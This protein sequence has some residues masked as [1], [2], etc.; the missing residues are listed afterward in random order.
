MDRKIILGILSVT[1][2]ALALSIL[3]PGGR[4]VDKEPKLPWLI[5][6]DEEGYPSVFGITLGKSTLAELRDGFQ[7]Q[8]EINL[9]VT[10]Q[11][12]HAIEAYFQS[13]YLSGI[14]AD[15]VVT[16]DLE[17]PEL[18]GMYDRGL[19][20]SQLES[21]AKKVTLS[22]PDLVTLERA[23]VDHLT[24]IP[25]TDLDEKRITDLFGEPSQRI[26]EASGIQHWLYPE[27][28]L[29]IAL[30]PGGKEVFQYVIPGKFERILAPLTSGSAAQ[31]A[32]DPDP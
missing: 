7:E 16:L 21:G 23:L 28:G 25:A 15:L 8:G 3:L 12:E 19:R 22:E 26:T 5:L 10:P 24:Y 31:S 9:F 29:N 1:L 32:T 13:L 6:V 17:E 27:K 4:T 2:I 30:N 11:Q 14:R 18:T 20:I